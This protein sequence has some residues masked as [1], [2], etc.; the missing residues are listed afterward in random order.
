MPTKSR[1]NGCHQRPDTV[2]RLFSKT[3]PPYTTT[4][5]SVLFKTAKKA[6][7]LNPK[8][9]W[10]SGTAPHLRIIPQELWDRVQ[11]ME[12]K[13]RVRTGF[14]ENRKGFRLTGP[15]QVHPLGTCQ[16]RR[17]RGQL[18]QPQW[19]LVEMQQPC[20]SEHLL[21]QQGHSR[22]GAC[23]ASSSRRLTRQSRRPSVPVAHRLSGKHGRGDGVRIE[24]RLMGGCVR[25]RECPIA[26]R[27]RLSPECP[28]ATSLRVVFAQRSLCVHVAGDSQ[29]Q[30]LRFMARRRLQVSIPIA[31]IGSE[32]AVEG[33]YGPEHGQYE[34]TIGT[35]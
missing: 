14:L 16:V 30:P 9:D 8:D 1:S 17:V 13:L 22:G 12:K 10:T 19:R 24:L 20:Q 34:Q 35:V 25:H 7:R 21:E 11:E 4:V 2:K 5:K 33:L 27:E 28:I 32:V 3:R 6:Y 15:S 23:S 18:H 29:Q 26:P 31:G